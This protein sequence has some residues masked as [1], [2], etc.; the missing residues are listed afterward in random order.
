MAFS[1]PLPP[2]TTTPREAAKWL[3]ISSAAIV[4]TSL[5]NGADGMPDDTR[6]IAI[7]TRSDLRAIKEMLKEHIDETRK[8]REKTSKRVEIVEERLD[9]HQS[10]IDQAKGAKMLAVGLIATVTTVGIGSVA[11]LFGV[12]K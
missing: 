6:D 7:E 4:E 3:R 2:L 12:I 11:K 1:A 5:T 10:L 9:G 8:Y